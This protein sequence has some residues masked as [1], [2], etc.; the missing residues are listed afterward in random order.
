MEC[1]KDEK[2]EEAG[3][4]PKVDTLKIIQEANQRQIKKRQKQLKLLII[5]MIGCCFLGQWIWFE[6]FG[7]QKELFLIGGGYLLIGTIIL[8]V[9]VLVEGGNVL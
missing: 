6:L 8:L 9:R 2:L 4:I 1:L 3:L 7:F 5:L